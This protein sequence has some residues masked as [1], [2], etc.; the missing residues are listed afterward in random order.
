MIRRPPRS[1]LFPY[2]TLF[3]SHNQRV[4]NRTLANTSVFFAGRNG[5]LDA[6]FSI[7]PMAVL[8]FDPTEVELKQLGANYPSSVQEEELTIALA[9]SRAGVEGGMQGAGAGTT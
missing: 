7:Y 4:D 8:P 2:T 3:R 9:K 5:K 1:T 6:G